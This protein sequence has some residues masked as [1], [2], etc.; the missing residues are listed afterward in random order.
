MSQKYHAS[1]QR[2]SLGRA[3]VKNP[4]EMNSSAPVPAVAS[5]IAYKVLELNLDKD[6]LVLQVFRIDG[7]DLKR[8]LI[9][10]LP[11]DE[12]GNLD[13]DVLSHRVRE[14]IS[15]SAPPA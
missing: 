4:E 5:E 9:L 12:H 6:R 15:K 11:K 2:S 3:G 7:T 1:R 8:K 10:P 13:L 14:T